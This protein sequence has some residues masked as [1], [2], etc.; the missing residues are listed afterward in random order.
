MNKKRL[1]RFYNLLINLKAELPT[2]GAFDLDW[3]YR[4]T[5]EG[6]G[7]DLVD[8]YNTAVRLKEGFCGTSACALGSAALL[9]DFQVEGLKSFKDLVVFDPDNKCNEYSDVW[10]YSCLT[11]I[12]AGSA[13]FG[14]TREQAGWLFYPS[15]YM[16]SGTGYG[17][18]KVTPE[19]V[20]ARVG[21]IIRGEGDECYRDYGVGLDPDLV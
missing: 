13:F 11:G 5:K 14:I 17:V 10:E 8:E 1:K 7:R 20:A 18:E 2:L 4:E 21:A 9:S 19:M 12:D 15:S 6:S 3:W 16:Y